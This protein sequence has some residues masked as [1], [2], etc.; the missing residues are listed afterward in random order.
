MENKYF[1][2][3]LL[4]NLI[5]IVWLTL[6][7][8]SMYSLKNTFKELRSFQS[9]TNQFAAPQT[10]MSVYSSVGEGGK[11]FGKYTANDF[12]S[13]QG[14]L[15][16]KN[17]EDRIIIVSGYLTL[18]KEAL[19]KGVPTP[20]LPIEIKYINVGK[21]TKITDNRGTA[22]TINDLQSENYLTIKAETA[23]DYSNPYFLASTIIV[24]KIFAE[25]KK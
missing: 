11:I 9:Q 22:I 23:T 14:W 20:I 18:K 25:K 17:K 3:L 4:I 7:S 8:F 10:A 15:L 24:E 12:D 13:F 19:A 5:L 2:A 21:N 6:I 16:S 1:K